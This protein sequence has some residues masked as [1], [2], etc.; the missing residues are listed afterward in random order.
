M[1]K[2]TRANYYIKQL[3]RHL[4]K[5]ELPNQYMKDA[6]KKPI[7]K[8]KQIGLVKTISERADDRKNNRITFMARIQ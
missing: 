7:T 6:E 8:L 4:L 2:V 5:A 3:L 1:V